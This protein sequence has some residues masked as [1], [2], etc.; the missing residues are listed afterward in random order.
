MT[1][2]NSD[3]IKHIITLVIGI[4]SL[5]CADNSVLRSFF[6]ILLL[7][8][9]IKDIKKPYTILDRVIVSMSMSFAVIISCSYYL[10]SF[11]N[12]HGWALYENKILIVSFIST[13]IFLFALKSK[14]ESQT[15]RGGV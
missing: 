13:T 3:K 10:T 1:D 9:L 11:L 7:L 2:E 14:C 6:G 4:A 5:T 12:N 8:V 15:V